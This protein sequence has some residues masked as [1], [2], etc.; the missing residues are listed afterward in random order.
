M[1]RILGIQC[2]HLDCRAANCRH[3]SP[4]LSSPWAF[5]L[6][7]A[8]PIR[9]ALACKMSSSRV[10]RSLSSAPVASTVPSREPSGVG[11]SW[12]EIREIHNFHTFTFFL[13]YAIVWCL[14]DSH[15]SE[16]L[17][18]VGRHRLCGAERPCSSTARIDHAAVSKDD[19]RSPYPPCLFEGAIVQSSKELSD[20]SKLSKSHARRV[21]PLDVSLLAILAI[22]LCVLDVAK[23]HSGN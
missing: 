3:E 19:G 22:S 8:Q 12:S 18:P 14:A 7:K 6:L 2:A 15:I 1:I 23:Q 21:L 20:L 4:R 5:D 11:P 16:T 9:L 13:E 17:V 10:G